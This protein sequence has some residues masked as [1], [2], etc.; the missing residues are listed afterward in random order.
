MAVSEIPLAAMP[1]Q[2]LVVQLGE[3]PCRLTVRQRRTGLFVDLYEQDTSIV[4]GVKGL[5][6]VGL[7]RGKYL[8]FDGQLFFADT[9]GA[10]PPSYE[11]LG[12]RWLLLWDD[13]A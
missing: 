1:T 6:R 8:G 9:Q 3:Q 10:E 12:S 2:T 13:A 11:G 5:D 7:V 4:L